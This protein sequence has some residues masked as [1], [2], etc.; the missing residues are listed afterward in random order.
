MLSELVS[1]PFQYKEIKMYFLCCFSFLKI[2]EMFN[3]PINHVIVNNLTLQ[4]HR[5]PNQ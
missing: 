5:K 3:N 2:I 1:K 4:E